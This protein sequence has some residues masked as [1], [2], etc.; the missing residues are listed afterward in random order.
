M[1]FLR[2]LFILIMLCSAGMVNRSFAQDLLK[3]NNL[4][5]INVDK[6]TDEEILKYSQQLKQSGLTESQA[7]QIAIA[8]GMPATEIAKLKQR[9]ISLTNMQP[10]STDKGTKTAGRQQPKDVTDS[11]R[12]SNLAI[13]PRI[14]GSEI[15]SNAS[16]SFEP[17]LRIATPL[18]YVLGPDDQ[19]TIT[20]YGVQEVVHDLTVSPEGSIYIPNVGEVKVAG[21]QIEAATQRIKQS[22]SKSAYPSLRSGSSKLSVSLGNIKSIK[23]TIIGALKP[24]NY[25][26]SSLSTVYNAL[27]AA[28]GPAENGS[29]REIQLIRNSKPVRSIDLYKFLVNGDQ[30]DNVS[31]NDN[32]VIRIPVYKTRVELEGYVKRPGIFEVLPG[33]SF[34]DVLKFSS[35]FADSAYRAAVKVTQITDKEF[36]VKDISSA[37][38]DAY[39]P[40]QADKFSIGKIINRYANRVNITGAVSRP[41]YY[42]LVPGM[43]LKDIINRAD[44]LRQ[45][46]YTTRGQIIRSKEDLTKELISFNVQD[47]I[48]GNSSIALKREDSVVIKSISD[49]KDEYYIS[50]QG[51][52]RKPGYY[53]YSDNLTVIDVILQAGGLTDAAFPQKIE[54]ARLIK[55][56]TL[57]GQDVRASEVIEI[58]QLS[59]LSAADKNIKLSPSDV[60]T[61]RRKPGYLELQS[62]TLSGEL[63]YPGPYVLSKREERVSDIIKRAGG[64][65]PEAYLQGAYIK[66]YNEDDERA[67]LKKLKIQKI[68]GQLRDTTDQ[69]TEDIVREFDQIPLD[70]EK[71]LLQPGSP[72]DVVLQPRDEIFI[73]K[74]NSQVRISGSV[75]FPTQIPYDDKY[76][77]KDYISAAGGVAED[78][79]KSR[80]Y[81]LYANGKAA[82]TGS[83]LFF[84]N[85]PSIKPGTEIIVPAKSEKKNKLSTGEIIGISS[86]L[87]SLAGVV[88]AILQLTK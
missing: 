65:T 7:E 13:D 17:N 1:K 3:A 84:K 53:N 44:G 63:Q 74:F 70:M 80:I 27:F 87:A 16:V 82:S 14:F 37:E 62:V 68:Q 49:L 64:F 81:V 48:N 29:F 86:A 19:V 11:L 67:K 83:F 76:S 24:G 57:T 85:Y 72:E 58:N 45:D 22:M 69:V 88:I 32:D 79:K 20:V 26:L 59:E 28:G 40:Q 18:N 46:A 6:L 71:I 36:N 8:R 39:K 31:L 41:G 34:S 5:Q 73:P 52:V 2:R 55:R 60:V 43:T 35:G 50:I 51:E 77:L 33:E 42:E 75:L 61:V 25:T 47:I 23:V 12:K 78:G 30:S 54:I 15:F 21:L 66:R 10:G 56:D 4:S 9:L 38:Y